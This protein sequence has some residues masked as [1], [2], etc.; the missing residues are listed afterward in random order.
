MTKMPADTEREIDPRAAAATWLAR[1]QRPD[2][3]R[4]RRD[5][6]AWLAA[7]PANL[8][9]YN[10]VSARYHDAKLLSQ[11]DK[12]RAS[13]DLHPKHRR[14]W[15]LVTASLI[16]MA[17]AWPVWTMLST[18]NPTEIASDQ[19]AGAG[20]GARAA[21]LD[22]PHGAIIRRR[23][24]DGS[25]ATLDTESR[26]RFAFSALGRTV[27]LE[28]GR[29]R[30]SVAHDGRPFVV[31]AGDGTI[32][33][34][35]TVFDVVVDHRGIVQVILLEGGVDVRTKTGSGVAPRKLKAGHM[36][37]FSQKEPLAP[38]TSL[39]RHESGWTEGMMDFDAAPLADVVAAANRY[40]ARP[41]RLEG[42]GLSATQISG[43]FR[44]D[45]PDRLAAN[46]ARSLDLKLERDPAGALILR[47]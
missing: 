5:L 37:L 42:A 45:A 27:W 33:A 26:M 30:F 8:L 34:T 22:N 18:P 15:G 25:L 41:I 36:L 20:Q 2:A 46:L 16:V 11:S 10:K 17:V 21:R 39:N 19:V 1:M 14:Q 38:I 35:G 6:D 4:Y 47:R 13:P 29:A 12:W 31:H 40:G 23:L 28:G 3:E 32:T 9:A 7:D 24:P 44:I 43:R